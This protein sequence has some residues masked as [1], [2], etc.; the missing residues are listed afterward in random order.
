MSVIVIG[1][2]MFDH[3]I[4]GDV[5]KIANEAPIPV[6][7]KNNEKWN[8]GGCGNVAA[9]IASLMEYE[10]QSLNSDSKVYLL[11]VSGNDYSEHLSKI[12]YSEKLNPII[13][14]APFLYFNLVFG[15]GIII[16]IA[17]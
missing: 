7:L 6:L 12:K 10:N 2:L 8:L 17:Y 3:Y 13:I 9:N 1:D 16:S 11:S 15:S 14:P 4:Y 5:N